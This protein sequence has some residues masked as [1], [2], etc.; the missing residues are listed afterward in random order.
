MGFTIKTKG[1]FYGGN[2]NKHSDHGCL[3]LLGDCVHNTTGDTTAIIIATTPTD[4]DDDLS[5]TK[6]GY[7]MCNILVEAPNRLLIAHPNRNLRH[8]LAKLNPIN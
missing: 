6:R 8:S 7:A 4:N 5:A 3:H 1:A 2:G